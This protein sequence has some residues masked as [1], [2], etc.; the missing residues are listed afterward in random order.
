MTVLY[1]LKTPEDVAAIREL[2]AG[3][4]PFDVTVGKTS[5]FPPSESS[6]GAAVVKLD[7]DSPELR[8]LHKSINDDPAIPTREQNFKY[9]PHMTVAYVD[10]ARAAEFSG[11]A[12]LEGTKIRVD[13]IYANDRDGNAIEIPLG[14]KIADADVFFEIAPSKSVPQSEAWHAQD[15]DA[16]T[17][18]TREIVDETLPDILRHAGIDPAAVRVEHTIGGFELETNPSVRVGLRATKAIIEKLARG[19]GY[20][21]RQDSV[22]VARPGGPDAATDFVRV[23]FPKGHLTAETANAFFQHAATVDPALGGGFA[24]RNDSIV[25]YN[26]RGD[27]GPFSGKD[28]DAFYDVVKRAAESYDG[29]DQVHVGRTDER[30]HVTFVENDWKEHPN[31]EGYRGENVEGRGVEDLD[32]TRAKADARHDQIAEEGKGRKERRRPAGTEAERPDGT[33]KAVELDPDESEPVANIRRRLGLVEPGRPTES[34]AERQTTRDDLVEGF[35]RDAGVSRDEAESVVAVVD[36]VAEAWGAVN[37]RPASDYYATRYAGTAKGEGEAAARVEFLADGRALIRAFGRK[38]NIT[39]LAHE[40]AHIFRRDLAGSLLEAAEQ[41]AGVKDGN[42]TEAA[43]EK[44]ARAFERY[45]RRGQAPTE[46]LRKVFAD[47]STWFRE[48]YRSV[49]GSPLDIE[50]T[51]ELQHVFDTILSPEA[52]RADVS[53]EARRALEAEGGA[54][55]VG[56]VT[57]LNQLPVFARD[58]RALPE[59]SGDDAV[60]LPAKMGFKARGTLPAKLDKLRERFPNVLRSAADWRKFYAGM[61]ADFAPLLPLNAI[62]YVRHPEKLV[63]L[64][65]TMQLSDGSWNEQV[66][67]ADAGFKAAGR[68]KAAYADG[69]LQARH[70]AKIFLWGILSRKLS[71]FPHENAFVHA[72]VN[73]IDNFIEDALNGKFDIEKYDAWSKDNSPLA[74]TEGAGAQNNLN[75]YGKYF[76]AKMAERVTDG[77]DKGKTKLAVLHDLMKDYNLSGREV[78]RRFHMLVDGAGVDNKVVSFALLATGRTDVLVLDRV[79]LNHLFAAERQFVQTGVWDG[80]D[81]DGN[82]KYITVNAYDGLPTGTVAKPEEVFVPPHIQSLLDRVAP[83]SGVLVSAEN[84]LKTKGTNNAKLKDIR[85]VLDTEAAALKKANGDKDVPFEGHAAELDT[86][87]RSDADAAAKLDAIQKLADANRKPPSTLNDVARLKKAVDRE[88]TRRADIL[89]DLKNRA[90]DAKKQ[91]EF[92]EREAKAAAAKVVELSRDL[93]PEEVQDRQAKRRSIDE[94]RAEVQEQV[95]KLAEKAE[96]T[97]DADSRAAVEKQLAAAQAREK[98]LGKQSRD[99]FNETNAAARAKGAETARAREKTERDAQSKQQAIEADL[100][101]KTDTKGRANNHLT[102]IELRSTGLWEIGSSTRG[103]AVYEALEDGLAAAGQKAYDA[104]GRGA[105]FSLARLHWETWVARSKQEVDHGSLPFILNEADGIAD[106][107]AGAAVEQGKYDTYKSGVRSVYLGKGQGTIF[108][109]RTSDGTAHVFEGPA[110]DR[111]QA[112]VKKAGDSGQFVDKESPD[113]KF[114]VS[115]QDAKWI[116]D[117]AN[118][119]LYDRLVREFGRGPTDRELVHIESPDGT[120]HAG[121]LPDAGRVPADTGGVAEAPGTTD[122]IRQ[123]AAD[124]R[125]SGEAE[126]SAAV[127]SLK[128]RSKDRARSSTTTAGIDV[129]SVAA[130]ISDLVALGRARLKKGAATLLDWSADFL[131]VL[132]RHVSKDYAETVKPFLEDIFDVLQGKTTVDELK[133]IEP[134][135]NPEPRSYPKGFVRPGDARIYE[136]LEFG[137]RPPNSW[138]NVEQPQTQ[139]R[140]GTTVRQ[141]RPP[142]SPNADRLKEATRYGNHPIPVEVPKTWLAKRGRIGAALKKGGANGDR[143]E[144]ALDLADDLTAAGGTV[145]QSGMVRLYHRTTPEGAKAIIESGE[146]VGKEDQVYF[147]TKPDGMISE[148]GKAVVEVDVPLTSLNLEDVFDGEAHLTLKTGAAG[149]SVKVRTV[150]EPGSPA[151]E[152]RDLA[153]KTAR[154]QAAKDERAR[155]KSTP[156]G[157]ALIAILPD[158]TPQQKLQAIEDNARARVKDKLRRMAKGEQSNAGLDPTIIGDLITAGVAKLARKT[159][160]FAEFSK[161]MIEDFGDQVTPYL[162]KAYAGAKDAHKKRSIDYGRQ[163]EIDGIVDNT[164]DLVR[165]RASFDEIHGSYRHYGGQGDAFDI[166]MDMQKAVADGKPID[167]RDRRRLHDAIA[168]EYD[169]LTAQ[170]KRRSEEFTRERAAIAA[171]KSK[172]PSEEAQSNVARFPV[173]ETPPSDR[174]VVSRH[175][176]GLLAAD[177]SMSKDAFVAAMVKQFG[178]PIAWSAGQMHAAAAK[179]LADLTA[180]GSRLRG[181]DA[182]PARPRPTAVP[183]A[184]NAGRQT[185]PE[186]KEWR[187]LS[188]QE[189]VD[190]IERELTDPGLSGVG[191]AHR[192]RELVKLRTKMAKETLTLEQPRDDDGK[193]SG[194]TPQEKLK[195]FEEKRTHIA[196]GKLKLLAKGGQLNAFLP[197]DVIADFI[198]VGA[199]KLARHGY[200]FVEF[201]H[202]MI[203]EFGEHLGPDMREI[204]DGA[205]RKMKELEKLG[206]YEHEPEPD[207][208]EEGEKEWNPRTSG[209]PD[210]YR[211]EFNRRIVENRP[212]EGYPR[213]TVE[214]HDSVKEKVRLIGPELVA[215]IGTWKKGDAIPPKEVILQAKNYAESLSRQADDLY[216]RADVGVDY[217][218]DPLTTA[219]KQAMLDRAAEL[220]HASIQVIQSVIPLKTELG[221]ALCALRIKVNSGMSAERGIQMARRLAK[222]SGHN[223]ETQGWKD[224]EAKIGEK[225]GADARATEKAN[226]LESVLR[227]AGIDPGR[228]VDKAGEPVSTAE[229]VRV[230]RE[231]YGAKAAEKTKR[232][233]KPFHEEVKERAHA[234][235]GAAWDRIKQKQRDLASGLVSAG[236]GFAADMVIDAADIVGSWLLEKSIT[237]A[238]IASRLIK[239]LGEDVRPYIDR[240]RAMAFRRNSE[241]R[242]EVRRERDIERLTEGEPERYTADEIEDMLAELEDERRADRAR[243]RDLRR[244]TPDSADPRVH[245]NQVSEIPVGPRGAGHRASA[246]RGTYKAKLEAQAAAAE[247]RLADVEWASSPEALDDLAAVGAHKLT[248]PD[249]TRERWNRE[250]AAEYGEGY[251]S[252]RQDVIAAAAHYFHEARGLDAERELARKATA[253]RRDLTPEEAAKAIREYTQAKKEQTA[254]RRDLFNALKNVQQQTI[255]D[256]FLLVRKAGILTGMKTTGRNLIGTA[257]FAIVQEEVARIPSAI[258]DSVVGVFTNQRTVTGASA[259]AMSHAMRE[260]ATRGRREFMEIMNTGVTKEQMDALQITRELAT[261][262]KILNKY[263]NTVFRFMSAQDRLMK[264]YVISRAIE[265]GAKVQAHNERRNKVV[266]RK[267]DGTAMSMKERTAD[268]IA[269]PPEN[270]M[271]DAILEADYATFNSEN[272]LASAYSSGR[273]TLRSGGMGGRALAAGADMVIPF[274]KT[275]TNILARIIDYTPAGAAITIGDMLYQRHEEKKLGTFERTWTPARQEA[276]S[277]GIGRASTGT[278]L[279]IIGA[280]MFKLGILSGTRDDDASKRDRDDTTGRQPMSIKFMGMWHNV[281]AL[282]PFGNI[283][284]LGATFQ[285]EWDQ[286]RRDPSTVGSKLFSAA[287]GTVIE[288]PM[289]KGTK[290]IIDSSTRP[291]TSGGRLVGGM[292]ASVIPTFVSDFSDVMDT[293]RRDARTVPQSVIARTPLRPLLPDSYDLLGRQKEHLKINAINPFISKTSNADNDPVDAA[294]E[295]YDVGISR[296]KIRVGESEET[297]RERYIAIG[298]ERRKAVA[299]LLEQPWFKEKTPDKQKEDIEDKLTAALRKVNDKFKVEKPA[300]P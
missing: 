207:F 290:D 5:T 258:V 286:V 280:E 41:W 298:K 31:G 39:G 173:K 211:N 46:G 190:V 138:E 120:G 58:K 225:A 195:A 113:G 48:I 184:L 40:V 270:L 69:R 284:A 45:V 89:D 37:N 277:R 222:R 293:S 94:K 127:S 108:V 234:R 90:R 3:I 106:P 128:A 65:R 169:R 146:M 85:G 102:P 231:V 20:T 201:T 78:R 155:R 223:V 219:D 14:G 250:M 257:G 104:V 167:A 1:G 161:Q 261:K 80:Y 63:A 149:K 187:K 157:D 144:N 18:A 213:E 285:R 199:A 119:G 83:P 272:A 278:A 9:S 11:R 24:A 168:P 7:I 264:V 283:L 110:Y 221:R 182:P 100:A 186:P 122:K 159:I 153:A 204:Y 271:A 236:P 135:P 198:A 61:G 116:H 170:S 202:D 56:G 97:Q 82:K 299:E 79:Q 25:F 160:D 209:L 162:R 67:R 276:F 75:D 112:A 183:D 265:G 282:S 297:Y 185:R 72:S 252:R 28:P 176:A 26:V 12:D 140:I 216:Q 247:R 101:T 246:P 188:N 191:K 71:P 241:L 163:F 208:R 114:R 117:P 84:K 111:W 15:Q 178:K 300:E 23:R 129:S 21:Y 93:S 158:M 296:P 134:E 266:T 237:R 273:T 260:M 60:G 43:E 253:G 8:A 81:K 179:R 77:P 294:L 2:A 107:Y 156:G 217:D 49:K 64:L 232:T 98:K 214:S 206:V 175:G 197:V 148:Y 142:V 235:V 238:E 35:V 66:R 33:E 139:T 212:P 218:G 200:D 227:A 124:M 274:V 151:A 205:R 262:S 251:T 291:A 152:A 263:V 226:A 141:G 34:A 239:E 105:D 91:A 27:D 4:E 10:P 36:A 181:E 275:P 50:I 118:A 38:T 44:F 136:N 133:G 287:A 224:L 96:R 245:T 171:A 203:R 292:A 32:R 154:S 166:V 62:E 109:A 259:S 29:A 52:S 172:V 243:V 17:K 99:L 145:S 288:Q 88:N 233:I 143:L 210:E 92:H 131:D 194:G 180:I 255:V 22:L 192:E 125:A 54:A 42:W 6:D 174:L 164:L 230:M 59:V 165:R 289:L 254:A 177:P 121:E 240:I 115:K 53:A 19:I 126:Q 295:H 86:I 268:L 228:L 267:P 193:W 242:R 95:R 281:G 249:M 256:Q 130:D 16:R 51:P 137:H 229:A 57:E 74:G 244:V 76:L 123:T 189:K 13:K 30:A 248:D 196:R 269:N 47:L 103:L 87:L 279:L 220:E 147:S 215:E 73:G 55:R 132:E 150:P 70:T 68:W